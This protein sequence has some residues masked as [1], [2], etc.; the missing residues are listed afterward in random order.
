MAITLTVSGPTVI[1]LPDDLTMDPPQY[2][3]QKLD[4]ALSWSRGGTPI[5]YER[6]RLA[7]PF[8]LA[9]QENTAWM[10]LTTIS[11][12]YASITAGAQYALNY[13]G[14]NLTVWWR[15]S[16]WPVIEYVPVIDYAQPAAADKVSAV[17]LKFLWVF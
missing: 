4:A 3:I 9:G 8:D 7:G 11:A 10:A 5:R 6:P 14:S 17:R 12:L 13:H 1:T 2:Q 16:D 15:V